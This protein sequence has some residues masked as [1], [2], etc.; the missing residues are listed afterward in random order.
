MKPKFKLKKSPV[1]TIIVD[2]ILDHYNIQSLS[3]RR[4]SLSGDE[5]NQLCE[6]AEKLYYKQ[7]LITE[8]PGVA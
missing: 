1:D 4:E 7:V 6:D 8:E 5:F 2:L 3:G